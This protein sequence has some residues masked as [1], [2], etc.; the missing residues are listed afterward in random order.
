M[1]GVS[2]IPK[3]ELNGD[4]PAR[5]FAMEA[6]LFARTAMEAARYPCESALGAVLVRKKAFS[7]KLC[8]RQGI[9]SIF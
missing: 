5:R 9:T 6:E 8:I 1:H 7:S 3:F 2:L 4:S